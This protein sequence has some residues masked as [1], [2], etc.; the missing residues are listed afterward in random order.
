[1]RVVTILILIVS[2]ISNYSVAQ[3]IKFETSVI[4]NS[5]AMHPLIFDVQ[6]DGRNDIVVVDKYV[7]EKGNDGSNIKTICWISGTDLMKKNPIF[8]INYRSCDMAAADID[9]DGYIDIIGRYDTDMNDNNETGGMFWL[10]NPHGS[11]KY[12]GEPWLMTEIGFSTYAKDICPADF[13]RDGKID[14]VSR[15]SDHKL[16]IYIQSSPSKWDVLKIDVPGHDGTD[17]GDINKDGIPDIVINGMW[18]ETPPDIKTGEWKKHDFAPHWYTQKTGAKGMWFDNNTK[19]VIHDMDDDDWPDILVAM[20]ENTGYPICWYR[21]PGNVTDKDWEEHQVGYMNYC[22]TLEI[23]DMDHDGDKDIVA[24][25][26][27]IWNS[28]NPEGYHP[29][30]VF[31][32]KGNSFEW[33]KQVIAEKACYGGTTG[34]IDDDGDIDIVAPRNWNR[35][36]LYLWRNRTDEIYTPAAV[37]ISDTVSQGIPSLKIE[38]P[39]ATYIYDKSGGGFMSMIDKDGNDWISF[40]NIEF[41]PP[42]NAASKYRGIPNLGIGGDDKDAGHPGFNMCRTKIIAPNVIETETKTGNW[43]FRWAFYDNYAKFIMVR[44]FPGV[45]YWFLYEGTPAGKYDPEK[46]Y[47]GN[48]LHGRRA[49]FPDLLG[50]TGEYNNW[51][52]IYTGQK[53]YPRILFLKQLQPD[54]KTDLFSYMG[55]TRVDARLSSDGMVC[56]GFGRAHKTKPILYDANLEFVM[57]FIKQEV[58]TDED[59]QMVT[60]F[61]GHIR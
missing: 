25:E 9:N 16:Y 42:G 33:E 11:T 46:M 39:S 7:D 8:E 17:I 55:N 28:P 24:G 37:R 35:G 20:A 2:T 45:P 1:M 56:F 51:E 22:H 27:I 14:I 21:N 53:N 36:P 38:T 31:I 12:N 4:S 59:N 32:N 19:V 23:A 61:I 34:D 6:K 47:W 54:E 50:N 13:N 3:K 18:I 5:V 49:D 57:G 48:N 10:K 58:V 26:L 41:D 15:G 44:T 40:R 43:K 52:W 30:I 60:R 29:V